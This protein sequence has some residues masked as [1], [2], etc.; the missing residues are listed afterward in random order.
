MDQMKPIHIGGIKSTV[1]ASRSEKKYFHKL[2]TRWERQYKIYH[3][4]P[5]MAVFDL[6]HGVNKSKTSDKKITISESQ[7]KYLLKTSIDFVLCDDADS[8]MMCIEYDGLQEGF[9]AGKHYLP[10]KTSGD[11]NRNWKMS[12]KLAVADTFDFLYIVL[13]SRHFEDIEDNLK[14]SIVDTLIGE[15]LAYQILMEDAE[16]D[17]SPQKINLSN[18]QYQSLSKGEREMYKEQWIKS[19][20]TPK[21]V[22]DKLDEVSPLQQM[23]RDVF[24]YF[25]DV[26]DVFSIERLVFYN[27][28]RKIQ[29]FVQKAIAADDSTNEEAILYG[30]RCIAFHDGHEAKAEVWLPIFKL[31]NFWGFEIVL[32]DLVVFLALSRLKLSLC[33]ER[34]LELQFTDN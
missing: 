20:I 30:E 33:N 1:F 9:S 15:W 34:Q 6:S 11:K 29:P 28:E 27:D 18:R 2:Q 21:R 23:L 26:V 19:W 7:W 25:G 14:I 17:F 13:G 8:P 22:C 31:P 5:F 3:N 12:F 4:L 32:R 16:Q 10:S 24:A